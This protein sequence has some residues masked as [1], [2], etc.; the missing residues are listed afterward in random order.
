M[1]VPYLFKNL[2]QTYSEIL[3]KHSINRK[4]D[5]LYLDYNGSIYPCAYKVLAVTTKKETQDIYD[6][7]IDELIIYT[8][9]LVAKFEPTKLFIM[10]DGPVVVGKQDHQR[11][12]RY[13]S[14]MEKDRDIKLREKHKT[15]VPKSCY[16]DTNAFSPG[17]KF[18]SLLNYRIRKHFSQMKQRISVQIIFSSS[19][20]PGEGEHKI[21]NYIRK[22]K[23]NNEVHVINGLDA[24]LIC[25]SV[26][27]NKQNIYLMREQE[28]KESI[29]YNFINIDKLRNSLKSSFS[30][31]TKNCYTD[32]IFLT[33]LFGNDFVPNIPCLNLSRDGLSILLQK[34]KAFIE[35]E[36]VLKNGKKVKRHII[37]PVNKKILWTNLQ[38]FLFNFLEEEA[39]ILRKN[40]KR[41]PRAFK[42]KGIEKS[43]YDFEKW[44]YE[45]NKNNRTLEDPVKLGHKGWKKRYYTYHFEEDAC[46]SINTICSNYL[47]TLN[48]IWE[49]YNGNIVDWDWEYEYHRAPH[50]SDVYH[51]LKKNRTNIEFKKDSK[52]CKPFEQLVSI[53]PKTS[54]NLLPDSFV[55]S[56]ELEESFYPESFEQ[57]I[58]QKDLYWQNVPLLPKLDRQRIFEYFSQKKITGDEELRNSIESDEIF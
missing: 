24:D 26:L 41:R 4:I 46:S 54:F 3:E 32:F 48:W 28:K 2:V 21:M 40:D 19:N 52:P 39:E 51:H 11:N 58:F 49:Y 17:T 37:N 35:K 5:N 14:V 6:E 12:R 13:K 53:L 44:N 42:P 50:L 20:V 27:S 15:K 55:L 22:N 18:M 7:I 30:D 29:E 8:E 38:N 33:F 36:I 9:G 56:K 34:Y 43:P 23:K 16:F 57:D 31:N 1:G 10:L 25:L 47:K 45:N